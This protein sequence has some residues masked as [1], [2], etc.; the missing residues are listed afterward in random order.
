MSGSK[1]GDWVCRILSQTQRRA[2]DRQLQVR[3]MLFESFC[4]QH[5][6]SLETCADETICAALMYQTLEGSISESLLTMLGCP[7]FSG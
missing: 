4:H 2:S 3:E 7:V 6:Q 5:S 1:V